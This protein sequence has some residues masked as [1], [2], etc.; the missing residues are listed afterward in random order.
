MS[1]MAL[2]SLIQIYF[3]VS[4]AIGAALGALCGRFTRFEFGLAVG[5]LIPGLVTAWMLLRLWQDY[6]AFTSPS[7][8]LVAGRVIAIE[9]IPVAGGTQP[10][11]RVVFTPPGEAPREV[12]GP[13]AGAFAVGDRVQVLLDTR[14]MG[15]A[16]VANPRHLRGAFLG[17]LLFDT[18]LLSIGGYMLAASLQAAPDRET[19]MRRDK[20]AR[21]LPAARRRLLD[22]C[23]HALF[24]TMFCAVLWIALGSGAPW[25]RFVQGFGGVAVALLGY[26]LSA[27]ADPRVDRLAALGLGVLALNFGVWAGVIDQL[28]RDGSW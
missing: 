25:F 12:L 17:F 20:R 11:P 4:I 23:R 8:A 5:L 26:A 28:F 7:S 13:R 18:F 2:D 16:R 15:G 10:A 27:V 24:V 22:G 19:A 3:F 6:Q 9:D 1:G 14:N 21:S